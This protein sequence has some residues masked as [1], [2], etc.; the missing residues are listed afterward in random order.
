MA[1]LAWPLQRN[2]IRRGVSNNAFGM[3]RNNHTKAHQGWDLMAT[4]LT[5]CYAIADG[6]IYDVRLSPSYG[7]MVFLQFKHA[8]RTLWAVYCH[9]SLIHVVRGDAVSRSQI[10]GQTGNTGNASNVRGEDQHL[11]FEIRYTPEGGAGLSGR[12]DPAELLGPAPIGRTV[13]EGHGSRVSTAG[14][15][16]LKVRGVNVRETIE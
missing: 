13:F 14:A 7:K 16:G 8:D 12:V 3:V 6:T 11:H 10:V 9:L 5:P 15:T 1:T 2:H 4:P